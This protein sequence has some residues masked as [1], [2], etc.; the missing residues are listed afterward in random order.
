MR[1][2]VEELHRFTP[3]LFETDA[4][5]DAMAAQDFAPDPASLRS[6]WDRTIAGIFAEAMLEV[7]ETPWPQTG[8]RRGLHGEDLGYLLAELQQVQR[9]MPGLTW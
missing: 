8:G 2:A 3:E 7:P 9:Q 1:D 5:T 4:V 6:E